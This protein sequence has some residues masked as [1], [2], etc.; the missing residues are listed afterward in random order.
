[1]KFSLHAITGARARY[2]RRTVLTAAAALVCTASGAFAQ[3]YPSQRIR[4]IVGFP[5]GTAPDFV[6]RAIAPKL[7]QQLGVSI[8][9]DNKPGAAGMIA[10]GELLRA[11]PDGYTLF[12]GNA[13]DLSITPQTYRKP[14]FFAPRDFM[15]VSM[16]SSTDFVLVT[17]PQTPASG[18][19]DYLEW[20]GSKQP[21][22]MGTFG[23]GSI[24]HFGATTF[25][26]AVK[27]PIETI[28]Y[29]ST[30]DAVVGG[31]NGDVHGLFITPALALPQVKAGKLKAIASTGADRSTAFPDTPTLKE[32]GHPDV[33]F[34]AWFGVVAPAKTPDDVLDKLNAA[35]VSAAK[36]PDVKLKL[37]EAGM[38]VS[39]TSREEFARV[40]QEDTT[41][42]GKVI[43]A[44]GFK[45]DE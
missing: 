45:A 39:G 20:A 25:G 17:N 23:A 16:V 15:P 22:L 40:I 2:R 24:A 32:Q 8:V 33:E 34:Y 12:L 7:Q 31:I 30:A 3:N 11:A 9:V 43:A 5:S 35:V 38:R 27:L 36:M 42:W 29:R 13:S 18:L 21:L 41:R 6:A 37:E 26:T 28:H 1:M 19:K 14:P 4:L 10:A 44:T